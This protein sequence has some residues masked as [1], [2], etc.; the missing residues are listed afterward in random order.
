[1]PPALKE[2]L[3]RQSR[4]ES[5]EDARGGKGP[6]IQNELSGTLTPSNDQSVFVYPEK[7]RALTAR[8]DG[9]PCIDRGPNNVMAFTQNQRDEVRDLGDKAGALASQP[10]MKQ[11]TFICGG[12]NY[13]AGG[14][15]R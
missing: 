10:G 7:A 6:L 13:Q 2:A 9:S 1:M 14:Y 11:Q 15:V 4:S 8:E 12:F 5:A 3:E